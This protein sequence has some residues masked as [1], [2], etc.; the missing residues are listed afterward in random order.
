MVR[1]KSID[2]RR[3]TSS[4]VVPNPF[5]TNTWFNAVGAAAIASGVLVCPRVKMPPES[6][7]IIGNPDCARSKRSAVRP[8]QP[9]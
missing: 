4:A 8:P 1:R 9:V 7:V 2:F 3:A 5:S 6:A